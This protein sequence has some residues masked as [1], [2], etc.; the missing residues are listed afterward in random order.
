MTEKVSR[1]YSFH[2]SLKEYSIYLA[3][4]LGLAIVVCALLFY[5][6]MDDL[7]QITGFVTSHLTEIASLVFIA[8]FILFADKVLLRMLFSLKQP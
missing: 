1:R 3:V 2:E 8:N 5:I 4:F 7:S 6:N